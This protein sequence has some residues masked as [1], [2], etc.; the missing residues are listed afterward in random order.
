MSEDRRKSIF[1]V[2]VGWEIEPSDIDRCERAVNEELVSLPA[3]TAEEAIEKVK[4]LWDGHYEFVE[5]VC[6]NE[7]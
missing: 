3:Y 1:T 2:G 5:I 7:L 6:E 4:E